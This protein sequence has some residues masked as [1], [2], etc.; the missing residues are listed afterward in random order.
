MIMHLEEIIIRLTTERDERWLQKAIFEKELV[1]IVVRYD[2]FKELEKP[3]TL[4]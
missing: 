4:Y 3:L 1:N 2:E